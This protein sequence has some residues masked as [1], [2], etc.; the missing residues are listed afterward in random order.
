[1]TLKISKQGTKKHQII[2]HTSYQHQTLQL[3]FSEY[4]AIKLEGK[5]EPLYIPWGFR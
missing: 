2:F 1:M 4:P 3:N 5:D